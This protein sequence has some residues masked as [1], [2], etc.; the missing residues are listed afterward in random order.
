MIGLLQVTVFVCGAVL[1]G[2][3]IIGS[4]VL[5]PYFG[6]SIFVWGSLIS[7]FLAGLAI[8]YY[9]GGFLAD[10]RPHLLAMAVLILVSGVLV[11]MVPV[12]APP[13]NR[14][15]AGLDFGPRLNPLLA[16]VCLF[17]LPSVF[18]GTIS[19]YAIK[20]A[21]SSLATI[22]NTA[23]LI[24]AISTAGSIVGALLTAFYLIQWIGVRSILYSL[25]ITLMA[26]AMLLI[27]VNRASRGRL[28]KQTMAWGIF[29]ILCFAL[30]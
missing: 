28:S 10:R 6:S 14:A 16:T 7:T 15:I 21:A 11:V 3:E 9:L 1:L 23:G 26:L 29:G 2:L 19:P 4:R 30:P 5:A 22:G 24:Y 17:F 13:V 27:I 18:M 25:G 12:V 8:G 20:L